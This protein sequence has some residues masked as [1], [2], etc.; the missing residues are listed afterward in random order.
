MSNVEIR[1]AYASDLSEA[2]WK[3]IQPLLPPTIDAG[4]PREVDL[5][6]VV[7]AVM[8]R[9]RTGCAWELLPHDLPPKSTVFEYYRAW[10]RDGT[11]QAIHDALRAQARQHAGKK[12][13]A[14][15]GLIDSQSTKT[16]EDCDESGYDA[17]KKIKGRKRHLLVDTLGLIIAVVVTS[18]SVQDR[19]GAKLVFADAA[20]RDALE[21]VRGD[22]GYRGKLIAWTAERYPWTLEIIERPKG[23]K[24]FVLLPKRWVVER[25]FGWFN[26]Y[27]LLSKE[28]ESTLESSTADIHIA[29]INLMSRRLTRP[30]NPK[31]PNEQLLVH[32]T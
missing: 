27:R 10:Q 3:T 25:T 9:T 7:N 1:K 14:T 22:G 19:D 13:T 8:Y 17:G 23:T 4:R 30:K 6:E 20:G 18:A 21:K 15:V 5:R 16:S 26:R 29:M 31:L 12:S 24:G 32:I 11:W 28:Y 2:Q